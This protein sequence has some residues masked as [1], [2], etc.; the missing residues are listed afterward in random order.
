MNQLRLA[1]ALRCLLAG[2]DMGQFSFAE[3]M[4]MYEHELSAA[5]QTVLQT[6]EQSEKPATQQAFQQSDKKEGSSREALAA[7]DFACA[8]PRALIQIYRQ[9]K[10][11]KGSL[12]GLVQADLDSEDKLAQMLAEGIR[13]SL[14]LSVVASSFPEQALELVDEMLDAAELME[15]ASDIEAQELLEAL[16]ASSGDDLSLEQPLRMALCQDQGKVV[17]KELPQ[18]LVLTACKTYTQSRRKLATYEQSPSSWKTDSA[19]LSQ[20]YIEAWEADFN[21]HWTQT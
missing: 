11:G 9:R 4:L 13:F 3:S 2:L 15:L 20:D 1:E 5:Q 16:Y 17:W 10:E 18:P 19:D 12:I 21:K 8:L 7:Q 14:R 6:T